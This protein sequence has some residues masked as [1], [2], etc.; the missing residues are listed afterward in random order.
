M[1]K[2]SSSKSQSQ[3][4]LRIGPAGWSYSDWAGYVYPSRRPKD[5]HEA[6]YLAEFFDTIEINTSF[7]QPLRPDHAELWLNR[8]AA[9]PAFVFTAKLWQKFTHDP[10]ATMEDERAVRAGF[11]V[12]RNAEKLGAI[13]LQFPFSFHRTTE[14]LIYLTAVLERFAGSAFV[15]STNPSS[16]TLLNPPRSPLH[17]L[18]MSVS[19]AAATTHGS[20]TIQPLQ[21]T[22][23]TII[24]TRRKS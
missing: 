9:N 24:S 5:F 23:G 1:K 13:L 18:V 3:S 17:P 6:A 8:V 22:S 19:T 15:T 14:T 10:S 20:A 12:L 16:A 7:Y 4:R 21:L 2:R 11:D